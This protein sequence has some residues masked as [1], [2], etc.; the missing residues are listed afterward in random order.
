MFLRNRLHQALLLFLGAAVLAG[1]LFE[2]KT[3]LAIFSG[4]AVKTVSF[5]EADNSSARL[6]MRVEFTKPI[7]RQ[8]FSAVFSPEILGEWSFEDPLLGNH[9]FTTAVFS[10]VLPHAKDTEYRLDIIGAQ[11]FGPYKNKE[12]GA[13]FTFRTGLQK[14][15]PQA[16]VAQQDEIVMLPI[17]V[18]WQD[19]PLSCEAA[20]LKMALSQEGV[21]VSEKQ[22]MEKVGWSVPRERRN[23][24]WGDPHQGFVGDIEGKMCTTGFGVFWGPLAKAAQHWKGARVITQGTAKDITQE[25]DKGHAV[26][27]WGSLPVSKL[28]DCSWKTTE[29]E[30]V[31]AFKETHVR[32][33]IGYAGDKENPSQIILNDPLAGRLYWPSSMFLANWDAYGRSAVV[34]E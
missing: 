34:L 19:S 5:Q 11:G 16:A 18:D 1:A 20:S 13:V 15:L 8:T 29:G 4:P 26:I 9:L 22:I 2:P 14:E 3:P 31:Q 10:S 30:Y 21:F 24:V 27:V 28:T 6:R 7:Q 33:V 23:N 32:L 17:A 12:Q 25:I